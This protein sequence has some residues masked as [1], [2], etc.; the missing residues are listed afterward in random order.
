MAE[1]MC[2][3]AGHCRENEAMAGQKCAM[4]GQMRAIHTKAQWG[5]GKNMHFLRNEVSRGI[6]GNRDSC[7][8]N[9][10]LPVAS[11]KPM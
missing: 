1:Q 9:G 4:A 6:V 10:P 3:L 7:Q 2:A 5:L 8:F 11:R